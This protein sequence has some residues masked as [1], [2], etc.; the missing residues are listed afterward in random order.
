VSRGNVKP[1]Y[2]RR[3]AKLNR[4]CST[5]QTLV[6]FFFNS[7]FTFGFYIIVR[8]GG[9][10]CRSFMRGVFVGLEGCVCAR[11]VG[12]CRVVGSAVGLE[13]YL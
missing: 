13:Y 5:L 8:G 3:T 10:L 6:S 9:C 11:Q 12:L 1:E 2:E 4:I 7:M